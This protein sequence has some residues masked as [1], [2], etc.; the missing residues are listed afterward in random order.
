VTHQTGMRQGASGLVNVTI[1]QVAQEAKLSVATVS[2]VLNAKGQVSEETKRLVLEVAERLRY[3]PNIAARSL[4]TS[5]TN[6]IGV[7]LPD[8]YGEFF[9]EVLRG[10]EMVSRKHEYHL[11]V[12]SMRSGNT[13]FVAVLRA[14]RGRVDGIAVMSPEIPLQTLQSNLPNTLPTV[15]L[16]CIFNKCPFDSLNIDNHGGAFAMVRH[17]IKLGHRRIA[18]IKGPEDNHDSRERLNG[19]RQGLRR[20]GAK[21]SAELEFE[22]DFGEESGYRAGKQILKLNPRPSAVFAANDSMAIGALYALQEGGVRVP[23][24]IALAGFDDIPMA[25]FISPPLTTV[26]VSIAELGTRS[27][28]RLIYG[29]HKKN[30]HRRRH[31]TLPTLIVVRKSCG[32]SLNKERNSSGIRASPTKRPKGSK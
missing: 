27:I 7:L 12:S 2:R 25:R 13:D 16:N 23:E 11:L 18:L 1:K 30:K 17:F 28:E 22:G 14:T 19:Y 26:R 6:T 3:V 5:R 10:M 21:W 29:I 24:E 9:S 32:A 8:L 15:V 20:H 31:E 4:I